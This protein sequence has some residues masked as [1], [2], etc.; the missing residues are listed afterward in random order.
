MAPHEDCKDGFAS[1]SLLSAGLFEEPIMCAILMR[2][3]K[4][5][6]LRGLP[7]SVRLLASQHRPESQALGRQNRWF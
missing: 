5:V 2:V 1:W 3:L 6:F 7:Q 4:S